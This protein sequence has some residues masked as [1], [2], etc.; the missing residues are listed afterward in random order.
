VGRARVSNGRARPNE[1]TIL[2]ELEVAIPEGKVTRHPNP[3]FSVLSAP[4]REGQAAN[5]T[6][7]DDLLL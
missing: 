1:A 5:K 4:D 7:F 6:V 3:A 2:V